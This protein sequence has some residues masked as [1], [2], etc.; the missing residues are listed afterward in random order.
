MENSSNNLWAELEK[1]YCPPVDSALFAA[2]ASDFDLSDPESVKQ[3]REVLDSI[4]GLAVQQE[5]LPFDP[6]GTANNNVADEGDFGEMLSDGIPT[7]TDMTSTPSLLISESGGNSSRDGSKSRFTYTVMA[8]GSL[9]LIGA[10]Y[11]DKVDSLL[12]MFPSVSRLNV[13][14]TLKKSNLDI[15]K[16]MDILLN[17]AFFDESQKAEDDC[18]IF[19][20]KG[21]DGFVETNGTGRAA[22]KKKRKKGYKPPLQGA[23]PDDIPIF[24]KWETGKA[25]I[26]FICSRAPNLLQEKVKSAYHANGMFLPATIRAMALANVPKEP[27]DLDEDSVMS[28]QLA[29]LSQKYPSISTT[30]LVGLLAITDNMISATEDLAAVMVQQP[31]SSLNDIIKF[32]A[33]PIELGN[34][35]ETSTHQSHQNEAFG[36]NYEQARATADAHFAAGLAAYQQAGQAA[37]RAKS[38]HLYSGA[39][40]VYRQR[41][42]EY[43]ELG[44]K[45]LSIASDRLVDGQSSNCDLDLHGVTV[46][47][48]TRITRDRVDA[49]WDG[50]GDTKHVRGGGKHVHGGFKIVTGVGNHS[51]DG[52]S[53]L[54][55]AVSKMLMQEGWRVEV[56][57]GFL[58][59]LGKARR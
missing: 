32:T 51:H 48:A 14:Q 16:S 41:G 25:D 2:V 30:T 17:L 29:E 58:L 49:W 13:E 19:M 39:A 43:R 56:N 46:A 18:Q 53:R 22:R 11:D 20:P 45:H 24:N 38:N 34:E 1:A 5:N 15:D 35:E 40:A 27:H 44:M 47:N 23:S 33:A 26:E 31:Q 52:T 50:L 7:Q 4:K 59:V 6:S 54:G 9:E 28:T 21:I 8:D 12:Q 55:P 42:Q 57:R 37:R 3:F 10:T 36:V